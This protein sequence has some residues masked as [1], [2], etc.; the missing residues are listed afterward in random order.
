MTP[1]AF[2]PQ[3]GAPTAGHARFCRSCGAGLAAPAHQPAPPPVASPQPTGQPLP[4]VRPLAT[5]PLGLLAAMAVVVVAVIAL[6]AVVV[7]SEDTVRAGGSCG[8]ITEDIPA[9]EGELAARIGVER[10]E[11]NCEEF[12]A[13]ARKYLNRPDLCSGVGNTCAATVE[14]WRCT[15]PTA[16]SYPVG[17]RCEDTVS[18]KTAVGLDANA[19]RPRERR[20]CPASD[21]GLDDGPVDVTANFDCQAA[22]GLAGS[23]Q[24]APCSDQRCVGS[25][26]VCRAEPSGFDTRTGYECRFADT[27]FEFRADSEA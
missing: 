14:G 9:T 26:F 10:G 3:C 21:T 18:G 7:T 19:L 22:L 17:L 27:E 16:G 2:C 1:S 20:P 8:T 4:P 12:L 13:V 23:L 24:F 6:L 5:A 15:I 25:G 11:V